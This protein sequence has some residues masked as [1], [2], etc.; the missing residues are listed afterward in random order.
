MLRIFVHSVLDKSK[1][2]L[3]YHS[4]N[5]ISKKMT[6]DLIKNAILRLGQPCKVTFLMQNRP[7][8]SSF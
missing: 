1:F 5:H 3:N 8:V 7:K 4:D 6:D 2:S